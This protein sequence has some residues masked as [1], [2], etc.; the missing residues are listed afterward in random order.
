MSLH[1]GTRNDVESGL[2]R[3][4][5]TQWVLVCVPVLVATAVFNVTSYRTLALITQLLAV[6]NVALMIVVVKE[7]LGAR[8]IGKLC[9]V[10]GVFIFYWVEA[11]SLSVQQNPFSIA[12][13]F[14]INAGQFDQDL[15]RQALLYITVFQLLLFIGYSF[16]P[17][18]AKPLRM[19]V[20]RIDSFSFERWIIGLLLVLCAVLPMLAYYDF[21][22]DKVIAA[23][24]A[25]RSGTD[26]EAPEPGLSQHLA[27]FGMYGAALFFVY[28]LKTS[29][30]RRFWWLL[31]GVM[32]AIPF[33]SGGARHLWLYI[34]LPSVLIVLRGF[35]GKLD[36]YR[37]WGLAATVFVVL[38]VAQ[39]Q[40]VYRAVGWREIGNV[41]PDELTTLN[42][43]GQFTALL[44]AEHLVPDEHPYFK[45]LTE[46]YFLIHWIPRQIWPNKP[47]MES[48]TFYNESYVQGATFNV[49]PSVIGQF[50]LNWGFPGVVFIGA[51]LGFLTC[52]ADRVFLLLNSD[53]QRALFVVNGMFYAFIV[54][55]FRF[56]SPI[57]FSY[58]LFGLMAM[59]LITRR[60]GFS[61]PVAELTPRLASSLT[62][63]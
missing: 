24:L 34:S 23:V 44:F 54:S 26:F 57:Y 5:A 1:R 36:R 63:G 16:R 56:Y 42:N 6:L 27:L 41:A 59:F 19:I 4:T 3:V 46:P 61:K 20:S 31:L 2:P 60:H 17:R 33:V 35:K 29:T 37:I 52:L 25:S 30:W 39:A 14:P 45:E 58:F 62:T 47:I 40:F 22:Y 9:L 12:E 43:T 10:G 48:W 13:G 51:W 32:A 15:I 28:A 7:A 8:V 50:H 11:L 55:S 21:D 53:K 49:T 38:L 18:L